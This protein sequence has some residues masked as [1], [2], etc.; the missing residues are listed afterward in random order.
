MFHRVPKVCNSSALLNDYTL[1]DAQ[2]LYFMQ[3]P[4]A[5]PGIFAHSARKHLAE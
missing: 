4:A 2:E 5:G 3:F 1:R